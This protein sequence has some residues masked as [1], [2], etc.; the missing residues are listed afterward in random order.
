MIRS[1]LLVAGLSVLLQSMAAAQPLDAVP[2]ADW[3]NPAV[4][5]NDDPAPV[6]QPVAVPAPV[7]APPVVAAPPVV[8]AP[9]TAVKQAAPVRRA[10]PFDGPGTYVPAA[11]LPRGAQNV[12]NLYSGAT[13]QQVLAQLGDR[14]TSGRQTPATGQ[15]AP[16]RPR[17]AGKPFQGVTSSPTVSPYLNLFREE[18]NTDLPN[19]FAFVRPAQEQQQTNRLQHQELMRLRRQVQTMP[20]GTQS[21]AMRGHGATPSTGHG[22]RY[23]NTSSYFPVGGTVR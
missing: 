8:G 23:F 9:A 15:M 3:G 18:N 7:V 16:P 2:G 21:T 13:S 6:M 1:S 19:Y 12:M 14:P 5:V 4:G 17:P 22:T 11:P 20:Y 10:N